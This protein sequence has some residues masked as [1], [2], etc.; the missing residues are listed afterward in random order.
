MSD[1]LPP[2]P[3]LDLRVILKNLEDA[4]YAMKDATAQCRSSIWVIEQHL[5]KHEHE[6]TK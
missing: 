5:R 6:K 3:D 1:E 2:L 4:M